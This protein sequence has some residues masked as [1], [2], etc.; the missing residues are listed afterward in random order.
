MRTLTFGALAVALSFMVPGTAPKAAEPEVTLRYVSTAPAKSPWGDQARRWAESLL[1][2][3]QGRVKGELFLS[4]QL[5]SEQDTISQIARGRL[6]IGGFS[7][8]GAQLVVPELGIFS[9]GHFFDSIAQSDCVLDNHLGPAIEPL[10]EDKGLVFLGWVEVGE[11]NLAGKRSLADPKDMIGLKTVAYSK[12]AKN[13]WSAYKT[14]SSFIGVPDWPSALQTGLV[15]F[16][17]MPVAQY[18]PSGINKV[19]PVYTRSASIDL[20]GVTVMSKRVFDGLSEADQLAIRR[21]Q[22]PATKLREEIRSLEGSLRDAH[23]KAGGTVIE[24]TEEQRR[25]RQEIMKTTWPMAAETIGG[26]A[27]RLMEIAEKGKAQ[28]PAG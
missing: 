24:I 6:D 9:L 3:S 25:A 28:C 8:A 7:T 19:A 22:E 4:G 11:I 23:V 12:V 1:R 20:P 27:A 26:E 5:G 13:T 17:A 15:D 18:V 21:A 16:I 2:E 10:F 14:N